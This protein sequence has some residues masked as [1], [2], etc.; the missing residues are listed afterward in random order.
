MLDSTLITVLTSAGVA[1]VF[2][3]LFVM[4]L[5]YP[6]AVVDD[7]K[8]ELRELKDALEAERDRANTAVTVASATRDVLAAIQYG[9]SIAG[10]PGSAP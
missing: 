2:C 5:I 3:I 9:K 1:G 6:K 8:E 7:L 4:G 10:P